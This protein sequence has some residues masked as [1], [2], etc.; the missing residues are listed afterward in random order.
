[1]DLEEIRA[2]ALTESRRAGELVSS[3]ADFAPARRTEDNEA[4]EDRLTRGEITEEELERQRLP[5]SRVERDARALGWTPMRPDGQR[6]PAAAPA[7]PAVA[8]PT[9]PAV[10]LAG[11][12]AQGA[13]KAVVPAP[14]PTRAQ[15]GAPLRAP[16]RPA[17]QACSLGGA[18]IGDDIGRMS[19]GHILLEVQWPRSLQS[20][21]AMGRACQCPEGGEA[22]AEPQSAVAGGHPEYRSAPGECGEAGDPED[23]RNP[24]YHVQRFTQRASGNGRVEEIYHD[25]DRDYSGGV[26]LNQ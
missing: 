16:T 8:A 14:V 15:S 12:W 13:P 11:A 1:M 6:M 26:N 9:R 18:G 4:L 3:R 5:E 23:E 17:V 24:A 10:V 20:S 25:D 19:R 7:K 2:K 21:S 22:S